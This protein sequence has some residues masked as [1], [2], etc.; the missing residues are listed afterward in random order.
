MS[1]KFHE[2]CTTWIVVG[3]VPNVASPALIALEYVSVTRRCSYS[4]LKSVNES[5][6]RKKGRRRHD[7]KTLYQKHGVE[8]LLWLP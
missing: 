3:V 5:E 7:G 8:L 6:K 2:E 1:P 4:N